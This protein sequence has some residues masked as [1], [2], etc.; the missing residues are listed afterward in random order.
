MINQSLEKYKRENKF[1]WT[2]ELVAKFSTSV[3]QFPIERAI[4]NFKEKHG[5]KEEVDKEKIKPEKILA[6]H[7]KNYNK[8]VEQ[9]E[10]SLY[11]LSLNGFEAIRAM[12]EYAAQ[13]QSK[14]ELD[15]ERLIAL[16]KIEVQDRAYHA[17]KMWNEKAAQIQEDIEEAWYEYK[18]ANNISESKE[19]A[20]E[21]K[22]DEK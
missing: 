5:Y 4:Y 19:E 11:F 8:T 10:K 13:F 22:K 3:Q 1:V 16:L 15:K 21:E 7:A 6:K 18:K 9:D 14:E 12:E 20:G 2:D 17:G